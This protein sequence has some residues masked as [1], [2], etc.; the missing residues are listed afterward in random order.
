[1]YYSEQI[2]SL[3]RLFISRVIRCNLAFRSRCVVFVPVNHISLL[4]VSINGQR[5]SAPTHEKY[6]G[7]QCQ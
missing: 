5:P 2:K 1:M 4:A 6:Q 7:G 3:A